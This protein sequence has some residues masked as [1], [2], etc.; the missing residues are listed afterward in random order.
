MRQLGFAVSSVDGDEGLLRVTDVRPTAKSAG[1]NMGELVLALDN[2]PIATPCTVNE[3]ERLCTEAD[4][5]LALRLFRC[6]KYGG[7]PGVPQQMLLSGYLQKKSSSGS[8][9]NPWGERLVEIKANGTLTY[10]SEK[11]KKKSSSSRESFSSEGGLV[12]DRADDLTISLFNVSVLPLSRKRAGRDF[13]FEVKSSNAPSPASPGGGG[14]MSPGGGGGGGNLAES[15]TLAAASPQEGA[16]WIKTIQAAAAAFTESTVM[17]KRQQG[18][19]VGDAMQLLT[20]MGDSWAAETRQREEEEALSKATADA[21][22]AEEEQRRKRR[23]DEDDEQMRRAMQE[24][25]G[26]QAEEQE[27]A[28]KIEAGNRARVLQGLLMSSDEYAQ[29]LHGTADEQKG[30]GAHRLAYDS[31]KLAVSFFLKCQALA[32]E[33]GHDSEHVDS[34]TMA[35]IQNDADSTMASADECFLKSH[36]GEKKKKRKT[37]GPGSKPK[38][39][40]KDKGAGGGGGGGGGVSFGGETGPSASAEPAAAAAPPRRSSMPA[41]PPA[42]AGGSPG[43]DDAAWL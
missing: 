40:V 15:L 11:K 19:E 42:A 27:M 12:D 39:K 31:Y 23:E 33:L 28:D 43:Y 25:M 3:F 30:R 38:D 20:V 26:S 10:R 41:S 9:F 34:A 1:V 36:A 37:E 16:Q 7:V 2:R 22:L 4:R 17:R 5:P 8:K 24:S 18:A 13:A 6:S 35:R 21:S 29:Q 14:P 32:D